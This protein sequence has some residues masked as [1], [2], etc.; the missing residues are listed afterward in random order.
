MYRDVQYVALGGAYI[1]IE[2]ANKL[3]FVPSVGIKHSGRISGKIF[4]RYQRE[5]Y[6]IA[7]AVPPVSCYARAATGIRIGEGCGSLAE[8]YL[9]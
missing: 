4:S 7:S 8:A 2:I 6:S 1:A 3:S 9:L 5:V